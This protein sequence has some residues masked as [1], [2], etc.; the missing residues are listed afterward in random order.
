MLRRTLQCFA[1]AKWLTPG[2]LPL[3]ESDP[4]M[5]KLI[6]SELRRQRE[7]LELIASENF[8]SQ[9]VLECLGSILT[10]K[11]AEGLP[12][13]RYYGGTEVV[14]EVE[15]LCCRR[16]LAAFRLDPTQWGVNVQPY[17]GSPANFA[18]YVGLL[19]PHDRVMGL[20]LPAGGHLTHGYYTT[21]RRISA[22]SIFFES[23]PYSLTPDGVVDYDGLRRMA[24]VYKPK[25]IIAGGSAYPLDWDYK[26]YREICDAV[27]ALFMMDM[28]HIS[29]LVATQEHNDPFMYADIV[30]STTHKTLRGPRS[31]LIFFKKQIT[32]GKEVIHTEERI[33]NAV[34]PALQ[35]GP[36]IHQIAAVATQLKEV[37]TPL[38]R[39]YIIQVKKNAKSLAK[40]LIDNGHHLVCNGTENHLMLWNLRQHGITGS[41]VE[42]LLDEVHITVNK[43]TIVGDKSALVPG[44]V[45]LGTPALTTRGLNEKDFEQIAQFLIRGVEIGKRLQKETS[46]HKLVEF[47]QACKNDADIKRLAQE[48]QSFSHQFPFPT[49][50]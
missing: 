2:C 22:S 11:Y 8:T 12:G 16:A 43:N 38:F 24:E 20:D 49:N 31:G 10:N 41:K 6:Q 47:V 5:Y 7:G 13:H 35:G 17:S 21:Q 45:R 25:L 34:F 30:T 44:G 9:A 29:G 37:N 50:K 46:S 14:D 3:H 23:L 15:R 40:A 4:E 48:V 19:Q 18:V 33:N 39:E 36:H 27:G 26:S 32:R 42:K 28:A 1:A